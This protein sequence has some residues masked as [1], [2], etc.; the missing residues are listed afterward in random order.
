MAKQREPQGNL[1]QATK[2]VRWMPRRQE[3]MK[4]AISCEKS[5]GAASR[6]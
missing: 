6:P 2:D 1:S 4:D 3:P 5:W